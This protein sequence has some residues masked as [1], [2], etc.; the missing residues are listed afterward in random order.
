MGVQA[1]VQTLKNLT[2]QQ[3]SISKAFEY[4]GW[5][6]FVEKPYAFPHQSEDSKY[7][8]ANKYGC[9]PLEQ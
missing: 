5:V 2:Y 9:N 4:K 1:N 6:Y 8:Q 7:Y 3:I